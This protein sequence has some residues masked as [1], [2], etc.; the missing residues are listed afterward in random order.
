K[1]RFC[2]HCNLNV[3]D[4]SSMT[5]EKVLQLVANSEGKLCV[6]FYRLPDGGIK[7]S[8]SPP[9]TLQIGRRAS[10]IAAGVFS[11]AMALSS[12]ANAY[13]QSETRTVKQTQ[14]R[15]VNGQAD[16]ANDK[17]ALQC[18]VI[19][20]KSAAVTGASVT[21]KSKGANGITTALTDN[22]GA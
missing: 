21:L 12:G 2:S 7:T 10:R 19:N 1:I 18:V 16:S 14:T 5:R 11:A 22:N 13:A 8:D 15:K 4:L 6:R 9:V 17:G 3:H 20:S